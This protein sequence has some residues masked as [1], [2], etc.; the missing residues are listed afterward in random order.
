MMTTRDIPT[1][2]HLMDLFIF[3][4]KR[5]HFDY[6]SYDVDII[7]REVMA[8]DRIALSPRHRNNGIIILGAAHAGY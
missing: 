1:G 7:K 5:P 3:Y 6:A 2:Q 8:S 4:R